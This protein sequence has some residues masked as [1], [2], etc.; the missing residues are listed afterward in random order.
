MTAAKGKASARTAPS[1]LE[2]REELA[3][4]DRSLRD[5][6]GQAGLEFVTAN[7]A[8]ERLLTDIAK[9]YRELVPPVPGTRPPSPAPPA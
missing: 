3:R 4:R 8:K 5:N 7:Y 2:L 9:L 1:Y 6:L